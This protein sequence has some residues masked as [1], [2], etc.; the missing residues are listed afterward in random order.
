MRDASV[1]PAFAPFPR[2][3]L[4]FPALLVASRN[5]I[6]ADYRASE[7]LALASLNDML[8][9]AGAERLFILGSDEI[10]RGIAKVQRAEVRYFD[11]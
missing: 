4:S 3:P 10:A 5:D 11:L 9:A 7:D 8:E 2:G 1:D 6:Y